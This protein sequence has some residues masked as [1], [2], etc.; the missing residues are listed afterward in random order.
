MLMVI[1]ELHKQRQA[2]KEMNRIVIVLAIIILATLSCGENK[3]ETTKVDILEMDPPKKTDPKNA[4]LETSDTLNLNYDS[5]NKSNNNSNSENQLTWAKDFD[6]F[7]ILDVEGRTNKKVGFISLSDILPLCEH[8]DSVVIPILENI[9]NQNLLYFELSSIYR[10]RF[11]SRTN[12]SESDSVFIYDYSTDAQ[13]S[14]SVEKLNVVACLNVYMDIKDC[15]CSQYDYMIGFEVAKNNLNGVGKYFAETL[16]FIGK[17]NPFV[18]GKMKPIVWAKIKP[19]K[20]PL[21]KSNLTETKMQNKNTVKGQAYAYETDSHQIFIQDYQNPEY[22]YI[23]ATENRHLIVINKKYKKV[24]NEM[25][26]SADEGTTL[27]PLN[28]GID[29][30]N[31]DKIQWIGQLFKDK[32][33]VMFGFQW[34]SFGCPEINFINSKN[35]SIQINCDNRH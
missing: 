27:A 32:P 1:V 17:E 5:H 31:H 18:R 29:G 2:L 34:F 24:E 33:E 19:E 35:K 20:F 12:I 21:K 22:E 3:P 16:V 28:F 4:K 30:N 8:S 9:D 25:L 7:E 26:L 15:P 6:L 10:K 11:L 13:L 23:Y 14:F